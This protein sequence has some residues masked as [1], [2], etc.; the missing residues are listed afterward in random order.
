M[1]SQSTETEA[2]CVLENLIL[3]KLGEDSDKPRLLESIVLNF[4]QSHQDRGALRWSWEL[5]F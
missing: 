2:A 5:K 1:D 4:P 3:K